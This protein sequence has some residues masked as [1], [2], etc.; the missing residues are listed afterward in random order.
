LADVGG[1][2]EDSRIPGAV[3]WRPDWRIE[4]ALFKDLVEGTAQRWGWGS[5]NG[6]TRER[7]AAR[8]HD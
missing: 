4:T 2:K 8:L 7:E 5:K 3:T 6:P 1:R